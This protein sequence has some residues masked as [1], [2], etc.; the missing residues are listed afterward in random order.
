VKLPQRLATAP[1]LLLAL[2]L[3]GGASAPRTRLGIE[4][5][6]RHKPLTLV[7]ELAHRVLALHGEG[8]ALAGW[9]FPAHGKPTG[10]TIVFLHGVG[11]N[12]AASLELVRL[13]VPMGFDVVAYDGRAHGESTGEACTYGFREK[14]D[15]SLVLDQLGA[16]RAI[17][18]GCSLGAEVALQAAADDPRVAGVLASASFADLR[19]VVH[20]R[21]P[22][23]ATSAQ[24]ERALASAEAEGGFD[25]SRV[26]P[27][28]AAARIRVPVLLVHGERDPWTRVAHAKRILEALGGPKRLLVVGGAGHDVPLA[29]LWEDVEDWLAEVTGAPAPQ[30]APNP[31]PFGAGG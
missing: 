7:P 18:I 9:F 10:F 24:V 8:I 16:R 23:A 20:E 22:R 21:A 29:P 27:V 2:L 1:P 6:P 3:L 28:L 31:E 5:H 25:A 30:R 17:L 11:D 14:R 13:L 15:L 4:V 19:S 12:R 26:S